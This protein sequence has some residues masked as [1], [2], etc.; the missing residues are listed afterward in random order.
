[1]DRL[2]ESNEYLMVNN[3]ESTSNINELCESVLPHLSNY[4]QL[5][6]HIRSANREYKLA[7][8]AHQSGDS[9]AFMNHAKLHR[10]HETHLHKL[11]ATPGFIPGSNKVLERHENSKNYLSDLIKRQL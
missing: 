6:H 8:A 1:M 4:A 7:A 9:Q 3:M 2:D 5:K 10:Q 11:L